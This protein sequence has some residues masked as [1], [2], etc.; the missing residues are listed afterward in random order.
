MTDPRK[1]FKRLISYCRT[2]HVLPLNW[3]FYR[4][5]YGL[6]EGIENRR[7]R[8]KL[9]ANH[10]YRAT[11]FPSKRE[12]PWEFI[13]LDPWEMNYFLMFAAKAELGIV[14]TGRYNGGSTLVAA[15][16]NP[17]VPIQS[18]DVAPQNDDELRVILSR[19]GCGENV[20][21]IVGDSQR[22]AHLEIAPGSYDLLFIDGDH[23][24]AGCLADLER[25]WPG[26]APGGRALM[27]D[28]YFGSEVQE[29][30]R[31]FFSRNDAVAWRGTD[32]PSAHWLTEAGSLAVYAKPA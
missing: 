17:K 14:E 20:S 12:L 29:A 21:L 23:S 32:V 13:R 6:R 2:K 10:G 28:C 11:T 27:H 30:A 22:G 7:L 26:L 18:I 9:A 19:L 16:A 1:S 4:R 5:R 25:W 31:L 8:R 3:S 15:Y 24:T